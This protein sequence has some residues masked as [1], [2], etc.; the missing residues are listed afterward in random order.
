VSF[1]P[2]DIVRRGR[3][4][5]VLVCVSLSFL[6][7]AFFR[8]QVLRNDMFVKQ[9]QGFMFR[10]L[11]K[12]APRG[13]ILD[14]N[15]KIIAESAVAYSV[16]FLAKDSASLIAM[17]DKLNTII[18]LTEKE[19]RDAMRR[20]RD[21]KSSR[22][23]IIF[24]DASFDKVSV[25]EEHRP[26]FPSLILQETPK[27]FYPL[28]PA[29]GGFVGYTTEIN[30]G[31]LALK[32]D[33]GYAMGQQIGRTGLEE[34]YESVLR[35]REGSSFVEV[36]ANNRVVSGE[37][38][39]LGE[40]IRSGNPLK[41]TIDL[42]L[43]KYVHDL[44]ADSGFVGGLVALEPTTGAVLAFHTAPAVDPNW[45]IGGMSND[46]FALLRDDTLHKPLLNKAM[47]G[48]Y[49]PG[50][51]FKLATAILALQDS[52]IRPADR[53]P[54][55]CHGG[56]YFG[57]RY[58]KCWEERGH[59]SLDLEGAIKHS[60]D[61]YFYQVGQK[62]AI[63]RLTG[64]GVDFGFARRTGIDIPG[65]SQPYFPPGPDMQAIKAYY[66]RRIGVGRWT[67][68]SEV[69]NLSI[70]QGANQQTVISM[71]RF[72]A[73]L[74][75]GGLAPTPHLVA[76]S[77]KD[78]R[79]IRL[80]ALSPEGT[81]AIQNGLLGVLQ[82]GGTAAGSALRGVVVAGKTG[83]A[84]SSVFVRGVELN[85]AWFAGF[86]PADSPKIVVVIMVEF[87]GHGSRV[88]HAATMVMERYLK[89]T[90]GAVNVTGN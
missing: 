46:R 44:F 76:D 21:T 84:Q 77:A 37:N 26:D 13:P 32:G 22:P 48:R 41:T 71:A 4:A 47:Y 56:Y 30:P 62:L 55:A 3:V 85:H 88:A 27:R 80:Y 72:Y 2:N 78:L 15:G 25:L 64:G 11:P 43:Q 59:G 70:G 58:W 90:V 79:P 24:P 67:H 28:G 86:A 45:W 20:W 54:Q 34:Q 89:A 51:T 14:R 69:L 5:S 57:N 35:G 33:S 42:D 74:A 61:V 81:Q 75:N 66:D 87:G 36:D 52:V 31:Q 12:P 53:M 49:A 73:A 39:R 10:R 60:C 40:P 18:P 82:A 7:T 50:S 16:S 6:L 38:E 63:S 68:Q 23:T 83:T 8:N 1:H 9:G 19:R 65:E 29:V 17:L